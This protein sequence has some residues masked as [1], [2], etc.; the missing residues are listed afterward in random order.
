MCTSA[1]ICFSQNIPILKKQIIIPNQIL[2]YLLYLSFLDMCLIYQGQ[3]YVLHDNNVTFRT[4][5]LI[6]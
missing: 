4:L 3:N 1:A 5:Y 6:F 2:Y